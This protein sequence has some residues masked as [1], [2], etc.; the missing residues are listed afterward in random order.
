MKTGILKY[1]RKGSGFELKRLVA[2]L[3]V[4]VQCASL[5]FVGAPVAYAEEEPQDALVDTQYE[6]LP[7]EPELE[8]DEPEPDPDEPEFEAEGGTLEAELGGD[9]AVSVIYEADAGIP[10]DATLEI[11][12]P[13]YSEDEAASFEARM[14]EALSIGENDHVFSAQLFEL[15][16]LDAEGEPVHP[17]CPVEVCIRFPG[18][19]GSLAE[20]FSAVGFGGA[21]ENATALGAS[22]WSAEGCILRFDTQSFGLFGVCSWVKEQLELQ[23]QDREISVYGPTCAVV[24]SEPLAFT[25]KEE[26]RYAEEALSLRASSD[27]P[28]GGTALWARIRLKDTYDAEQGYVLYSLRGGELFKRLRIS[29]NED[30]LIPLRGA[31]G[32]ALITFEP[33]TPLSG[34]VTVMLTGEEPR[35][36]VVTAEDVSDMYADFDLSSLLEPEEKLDSAFLQ[37]API[38]VFWALQMVQGAQTVQIVEN[39]DKPAYELIGA[40]DITL[41]LDDEE[42]QPDAD[43]PI[44][45]S[46]TNPGI[47][48][49]RDLQLWH[50][51][52]DDSKE[53]ITDFEVVG[54][55]LSFDAAGFSVYLI[56]AENGGLVTPQCTFTFHVPNDEGGYTEYPFRDDQGNTVFK[57]TIKSGDELIVPQPV[58]EENMS[59]AGWYQGTI[60]SGAV[61]LE[62]EPYDFDNIQITE[63]SA[64]DLYAVFNE[65]SGVLFYGQY[66]E[67]SGTFPLAYTRRAELSGGTATVQISDVHASYTRSDDE[68]DMAFF[69]WSYTPISTPG[70]ELDDNGDP[71]ARIEGD[72]IT[73]SGQTKLYPIFRPIHWLRFYAAK[74]G[75]GAVYNAPR[76]YYVDDEVTT[77]LPT[78]SLA[79]YHFVGWYIG[80][81]S[82]EAADV[83]PVGPVKY[84]TQLTDENG[85]LVQEVSYESGV[86]VLT[87]LKMYI[88]KDVTIYAKWE[89]DQ[90]ADY[91]IAIWKQLASD[92]DGLPEGE[93]H[94]EY[95]EGFTL[96]GGVGSTVSV[97][98]EYRQRVYAGYSYARCDDDKTVLA[99]GSTVLNVYYDKD[100]GYSPTG[101]Y[102][103][104]FV[105]SYTGDTLEEI[106]A[107]AYGTPLAGKTPANPSSTR[108]GYEFSD[109]YLDNACTVSANLSAMTMP[110]HDLTVY[111]GWKLIWYLVKIDPNYGELAGGTGSTW[112]WQTIEDEPIGEYT[113]VTRNYVPSSSGS[114]YYVKHDLAYYND[115]PPENA[116]RKTYYTTDPGEAT[117]DT[118]FERV[119][120]VYTY[121]GWY[122][123]K[124]GAEESEPYDFSQKVNHDTTLRLHW[125]KNGVYYL[126]YNAAVSQD[127]SATISGTVNG[128]AEELI[129]APYE[130]YA[131]I[132]LDRTADPPSG[133]T[134]IGWQVR[135]D[136]SGIV[137]R[138]GQVLTLRADCA[139]RISGKDIVY[140]DAVYA[141][142]GTASVVYDANG[143]TVADNGV[144]F[145]KSYNGEAWEDAVGTVDTSAGTATVS[146]LTNNSRFK[147]SDGRGFHKDG[148]EFLGWSNRAAYDPDDPGAVFFPKSD[149]N[150]IYGVDTNDPKL[151]AVWGLKVTYH[152]NQ[153]E[154]EWG[155]AGW[156]GYD[157]D[158]GSRTYSRTVYVNN[159][160][161]EPSG[162]PD[163][164]G[165]AALLFRYWTTASDSNTEYDFSQPVTGALDLYGYWSEPNVIQAH[166]VDA[167]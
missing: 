142:L 55:T 93:K 64:V 148:G 118:T 2:M 6:E 145:G 153:T 138:P 62:D 133:Y 63:N 30:A 31:D 77:P 23:M 74:S 18:A 141:K 19:D 76:Y 156:D 25:P 14:L 47:R 158:A 53:R 71:V 26:N 90:Q 34:D 135:G 144:D 58:P 32:F 129:D 131:V 120:G 39:P 127:G 152:L 108:P 112:F 121:A 155:A 7:E 86:E 42:F 11:R 98:E 128:Q 36:I 160:V 28:D 13:D 96:T 5:A 16:I 37:H 134:F 123:V 33:E 116:D 97:P 162:I 113:Y 1:N 132:T 59:F 87:G 164:T 166:A 109:W 137:Y 56:V 65:F 22:G 122:E 140:L 139:V 117:E 57:Q 51:H 100:S 60:V 95:L 49:D 125:K 151:Y 68:T 73:I 70:A 80:S 163:Y 105:D 119:P 79:G 15:Y 83:E 45:V 103:L 29:E 154:A 150:A 81:L 21:P 66:D 107:L 92:A 167:S 89:A 10:A 157:Y 12:V 99:D 102:T 159:P 82:S 46:I 38:F 43:H 35:G 50:I 40:Y 136:D 126:A 115:D 48:E 161:E 106:P 143:G 54:N 91:T 94:Y 41:T 3:L 8:E 44:R 111:A 84:G 27:A 17:A 9:F 67:A 4:L 52:D 147:L 72:S 61:V 75:K 24:S 165:S 124:N 20:T 110:D 69:G 114:Y 130:D 149:T 101:S 88:H 85:Q 146:G 78:T 104:K